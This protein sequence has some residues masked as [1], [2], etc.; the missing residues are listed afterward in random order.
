[1]PPT[2]PVP[3]RKG[4]FPGPAASPAS[5]PIPDTCLIAHKKEDCLCSL[6]CHQH[7]VRSTL[8]VPTSLQVAAGSVIPAPIPVVEGPLGSLGDKTK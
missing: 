4:G 5:S 3:I 6:V 1:M 2:S 8:K 7:L